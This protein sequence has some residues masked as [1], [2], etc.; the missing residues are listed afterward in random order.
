MLPR[1]RKPSWSRRLFR[2]LLVLAVLAAALAI[3]AS[4]F[5]PEAEDV[6]GQRAALADRQAEPA[7]RRVDETSLIADLKTLSDPAM[8]GRKVGT[9]G[10]ARARAYLLRRYRE[11]GLAPL[12]A[13]HEQPFSFTPHRGIRFWR[14]KFWATREPVQGVNVL[15]QIR[16]TL[17]PDKVIVVSAHYDHLGVREGKL[18]AGADDNASGVAALLATARWF[19]QHPPRHTLVF[20]AF[21]GEESGLRGAQAFL[22]AKLVPGE[23]I[24]ANINFDMLSRSNTNELFASGLYANPQLQPA[25]DPLRATAPATLLYGHDHP[26]PFWD[27]DDWTAQSDQGVFHDA[28]LAFLYFGVADHPDYHSPTDTFERVDRDFYLRAVDLV[29][30]AVAAVDAL[31]TASIGK[32][33]EPAR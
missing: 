27:M 13:S 26:R 23:R 29:V 15:G 19:K 8:E 5:H 14:A 25:L 11:L 17:E 4:R 18:Y 7:L 33:P 32:P 21:D 30:G 3:Y 9:P 12:G 31:P 2:L 10:G 16:G 1:R 24:L 20:A 28:G 6:P 22:D